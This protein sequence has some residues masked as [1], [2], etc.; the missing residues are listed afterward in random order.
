MIRRLSIG[1]T[2]A[3][4]MLFGVSPAL[5]AGWDTPILYSAE[6]MGMGGAAIGYVDDPSA[7]YHNPAGI[8]HTQGL[9]L[10]ANATLILGSI[11]SSPTPEAEAHNIDS[12]PIRAVAPLIAVTYKFTDWFA[13]GL[14]FYPVASAG[15]VYKYKNSAGA[16]V[17]NSTDVVFLEI[18]PSLAFKLP[19]NVYLGAGYRIS[20][21]SLDRYA[22]PSAT[23]LDFTLTGWNY[24]GLR[25][26]A[27]WDPIPELQLGIVYR[28]KTTT[29]ITDD[30]G[31]VVI[32]DSPRKAWGD[33][34]LP[35]KLGFGSRVNLHPLSF[36]LDLEYTWQSQNQEL[37]IDTDPNLGPL[38][39][40]SVFK[41]SDTVTLRTGVEYGLDDTY[42][43]RGGFIFDTQATHKEWPSAFGTPPGPSYTGTVGFGYKPDAPWDLNFALAYRV[44][45]ATVSTADIEKGQHD[46]PC[47][48]CSKAGDY[49]LS[50]FGAYL[51]F[52]YSFH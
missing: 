27:Q 3:L 44:G 30:S 45:A 37:V 43:I 1:S 21:V 52:T 29:R 40:N 48:A 17:E 47:A 38:K 51:D 23:P 13:A 26:G 34:V 25:F 42:F 31:I 5:A 22:A 11:T 24:E 10:M 4:A 46:Y 28:H 49:S 50:M 15:A 19:G 20:S 2:L 36:V 7:I 6:H 8:V 12:E 18:S 16:S 33:L 14:A 41:W 9:T 35:S 39:V 32:K